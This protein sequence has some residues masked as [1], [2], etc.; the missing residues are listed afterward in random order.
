MEIG[1]GMLIFGIFDAL[2]AFFLVYY[3]VKAKF[4]GDRKKIARVLAAIFGTIVGAIYFA[5]I[6]WFN[7]E[8]Y[9]ISPEARQVVYWAPIVLS[10]LMLILVYLSQPPKKKEAKPEEKPEEDETQNNTV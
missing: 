6:V 10:A 2:V 1:P 5:L 9:T 3:V 4:G 7:T 8:T